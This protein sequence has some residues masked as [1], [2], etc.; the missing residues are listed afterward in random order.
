M[1][2]TPVFYPPEES[3]EKPWEQTR[4]NLFAESSEQSLEK[5]LSLQESGTH[6]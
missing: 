3:V 6:R 4:E 2:A 5:S 1:V